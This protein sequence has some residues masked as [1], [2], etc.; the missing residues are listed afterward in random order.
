M[1]EELESLLKRIQDEGIK[2]ADAEKEKIISA[3]R[4]EAEGIVTEAR[5]KADNTIKEAQ[6]EAELYRQKGEQALKQAARDVLLSLRARLQENMKQVVRETSA[7]S[8]D[9]ETVASLI[10]EIV[11]AYNEKGGEVE[12]L[13]VLLPQERLDQVE[14]AFKPKL[15]E[16]LKAQTEFHPVNELSGGFQL[17]FNNEDVVYDFSDEALAETISGFL[18]SRLAEL[19]KATVTDESQEGKQAEQSQES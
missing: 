13:K 7:G 10:Q 3:A 14:E 16:A 5:E 17:V 12:S 15:G 2:E 4:E 18:N 9:G 11:K 19:V 1:A 8:M 6:N